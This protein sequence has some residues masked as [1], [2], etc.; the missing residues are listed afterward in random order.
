MLGW[1]AWAGG[2]VLV[3]LGNWRQG[4][5]GEGKL[6]FTHEAREDA[7]WDDKAAPQ[8]LY[9]L[10]SMATSSLEGTLRRVTPGGVLTHKSRMD[11]GCAVI[12]EHFLRFPL[13][14]KVPLLQGMQGKA[15]HHVLTMTQSCR[16]LIHHRCVPLIDARAL[17]QPAQMR[18]A[19]RTGSMPLPRHA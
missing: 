13:K 1:Y 6:P 11:R 19:D 3:V 14:L 15:T 18:C 9:T 7:K 10:G 2:R 5:D 4:G 16:R 8:A 17:A 12:F